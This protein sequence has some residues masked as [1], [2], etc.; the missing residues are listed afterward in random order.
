MRITSMKKSIFVLNNKIFY[1]KILLFFIFMFSLSF[2]SK[3]FAAGTPSQPEIV[4]HSVG[5]NTVNLVW[6]PPSSNGGS[7]ITNYR[8]EYK[9][10]TDISW[11][12]TE[13][14][15]TSTFGTITS[16]TN[17]SSYDFRVSA[18]NTNGVGEAS[19]IIIATPILGYNV[20]NSGANGADLVD[21]TAAIQSALDNHD[22]V[23]IPAG[24]YMI[25]ADSSLNLK[26]NQTLT[27]DSNAILKMITTLRGNTPEDAYSVIT[28]SNVSNVN[29]V[30]GQIVGDRNTHSP[31]AEGTVSEFGYGVNIENGA[32]FIAINGITISNCWGDGVFLGVDGT[33]TDIVT[34][35][36]INNVIS[37]NNRRQGL[38]IVVGRKIIVANSIFRNTNGTAPEAGIDLEPSA[39]WHYIS[40]I[41][42]S[43]VQSYENNGDGMLIYGLRS[44]V[45]DITINDSNFSN[46]NLTSDT[47]TSYAG[48][49]VLYADGLEVN[50]FVANGNA[51]GLII[52]TDTANG[53]FRSTTISENE[54][55]GIY[56]YAQDSL[57]TYNFLFEDC[58]IQN[59][60]QSILGIDDGVIMEVETSGSGYISNVYFNRCEVNDNQSTKT[61]RYGLFVN[62]TERINN[63]VLAAS[64]F[65]DNLL[66]NYLTNGPTVTV[67]SESITVPGAP[68]NLLATVSNNQINLNWNSPLLDGG[69]VI[70]DYKLEYKLS[71]DSLWTAVNIGSTIT[72]VLIT[73]LTNANYDFRVSA[74]S[75][76]GVGTASLTFT[77]VQN[78][79]I[80]N[81]YSNN[82]SSNNSSTVTYRDP[83]AC[84]DNK[85]SSIPDLFQINVGKNFAKLYFTP[86]ND[87]NG[88][89]YISFSAINYNA[90]EHGEIV[91][92]AKEGVQSHTIYML[93]PN[94]TYYVK[95]RGQ[96]GCMPG[97]WS[98][99]MKIRTGLKTKIF[100]KYSA[101]KKNKLKN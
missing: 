70:T 15:S 28:I 96:N 8:I 74:I 76:K 95:V 71:N 46:N 77:I 85:P 57:G 80:S 4:N 11:T 5:N 83:W 22:N 59:N 23:Y 53:V 36:V 52:S 69:S 58:V 29:V 48:L 60:S 93:K 78:G 86:L 98:T 35:V 88:K 26:S 12:T 92:L 39:S 72:S 63:V 81:N 62:A 18:I 1:F 61:Q 101:T 38:S 33:L 100:Y 37:E 54:R 64:T 89:Y 67:T 73:G 24:T 56:L 41:L 20:T 47:S 82:N 94:T 50:N 34:D 87:T 21:D 45:Q 99:I 51:R 14:G 31:P 49:K 42:F 27:M 32:S 2:K 79:V 40:D 30:G 9:L 75:L 17:E 13:I 19:E 10:S 55:Q 16:L 90:E 91:T 43:N 7:V 6:T 44:K 65:N 97:E 84:T 3:V 68:T 25:N 66:G